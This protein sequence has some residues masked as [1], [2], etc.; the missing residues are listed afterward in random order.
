[1]CSTVASSPI[2]AVLLAERALT[3][4][5]SF[6]NQLL[7]LF[8]NVIGSASAGT[9]KDTCA[10][11]LLPNPKVL[12]LWYEWPRTNSCHCITGS[13]HASGSTI[14]HPTCECNYVGTATA[15]TQLTGSCVI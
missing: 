4:C 11:P 10:N 7:T 2:L 9:Q 8:V 3:A 1:M 6:Q 5:N 14:G 13:G 15:Y 12:P